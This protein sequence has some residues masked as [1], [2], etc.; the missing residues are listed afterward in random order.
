MKSSL[1]Y[2]SLVLAL[3]VLAISCKKND[4][5][6]Q[7]NN[8]SL[9][10]QASW[11]Y[12]TAGVGADSSGTIVF[13]LPPGTIKD[14]QRDNILTFKSDSTGTNDEGPTKCNQASPQTVPFTW[15]FSANQKA[16]FSTDSLFS[17]VGGSF[18]IT[19]LTQTQLHLLKTVTVQNTPVILNVYL[20]H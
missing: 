6:Q 9:I 20:K 7:P 4:T 1:I 8:M 12:D 10:T 19:S 13:A 14:C 11:K 17:G 15:S 16:L 18:A 2:L 3:F 5:T